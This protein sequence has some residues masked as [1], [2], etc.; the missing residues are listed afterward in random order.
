MTRTTPTVA[1]EIQ[2]Y[3]RTGD[4]DPLCL[5]WPGS[6]TLDC[7]RRGHDELM[8]ALIGEVTARTQGRSL[9]PVVQGLDVVTFTRKKV[10]PMVRGLFPRVEHD[11][12]LELVEE[13]VVFLAPANIQ[14]VLL[15]CDW[16]SSAWNVANLYLGSIGAQLLG[17][18]AP[19]IVGM[20]QHATC[21]V[22]PAYFA[23]DDP[24][25]DFVVHEVAH[26]FHNCK[27]RTAG[28]KHTRRKEWLLDI[29]FTE[30][31]TFA[32]SCEVFSCISERAKG[33]AERVALAEEYRRVASVGDERV[34]AAVVADIVAEAASRRNGWRVILS[35]C[36]PPKK[37]RQA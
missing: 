21:Y 17:E 36:A 10:G 25:A 3:L 24:F 31:E 34:D 28:L 7:A 15:D 27:R 2:R 23:D 26:I 1:E 32:Y 18:D 8:A 22:S 35:R 12:V 6:N 5:A 19:R 13:S 30:R 37:P 9:P 16:L 20:S 33:L 14:S 4:S 11:I 29:E